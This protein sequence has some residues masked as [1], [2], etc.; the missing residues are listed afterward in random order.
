MRNVLAS[1]ITIPTLDQ[2]VIA[3]KALH[4]KMLG[5]KKYP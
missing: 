1:K 2:A 3:R 4:T 5:I